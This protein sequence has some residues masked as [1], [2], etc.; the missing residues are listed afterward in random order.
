MDIA[1]GSRKGCTSL[2]LSRAGSY[3]SDLAD[4]VHNSIG[5]LDSSLGFRVVASPPDLCFPFPWEILSKVQWP[6]GF[7]AL[8]PNSGEAPFNLS[9]PPSRVS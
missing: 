7:V 2:P 4:A 1:S 8:Y 5:S 3:T 9:H 6:L